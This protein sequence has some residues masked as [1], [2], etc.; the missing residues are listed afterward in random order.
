MLASLLLPFV[1]IRPRQSVSALSHKEQLCTDGLCRS[2]HG[3]SW[4]A[5]LLRISEHTFDLLCVGPQGF[6]L[7]Q[8]NR[9]AFS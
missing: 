9:V 8:L 2:H 7:L 1:L 6:T 3:E 5:H 4:T